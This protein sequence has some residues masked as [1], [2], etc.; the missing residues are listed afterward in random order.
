MADTKNVKIE[1][2]KNEKVQKIIYSMVDHI[3]WEVV[4]KLAPNLKAECLKLNMPPD[5][6]DGVIRALFN[7][8]LLT[9]KMIGDDVIESISVPTLFK[10]D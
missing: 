7:H 4:E 8:I 9:F 5:E 10:K 2:T 6:I 1:D 3:E